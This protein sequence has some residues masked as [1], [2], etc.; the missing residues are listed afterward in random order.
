[1]LYWRQRY[2]AFAC[3]A[4]LSLRRGVGHLLREI[5]GLIAIFCG[6]DRAG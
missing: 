1:V 4:S 3:I 2:L 5:D 6:R